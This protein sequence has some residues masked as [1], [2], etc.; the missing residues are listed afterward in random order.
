MI[1]NCKKHG[2][3]DFAFV[4]NGKNSKNNRY[5]CRKCAIDAVN[6]RR[7][8]LKEKAV[9]YKGGKCQ[10]CN[11]NKY[12]GALE[13]HH[14]EKNKEFGIGAK[15][16]TRSWEALKKELDKCILV[17]SNCHKEIEAGII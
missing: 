9:I 5:R 12:M 4:K 10:K 3:T 7:R 11:Y 17:C 6:K 2:L 1:K 16:Y 14:I 13:F 15:G 8:L